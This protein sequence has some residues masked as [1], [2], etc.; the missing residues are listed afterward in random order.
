[1]LFE[2]LRVALCDVF[3]FKVDPGEELMLVREA[4]PPYPDRAAARDDAQPSP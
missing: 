3:D 4:A 1:V 2:E